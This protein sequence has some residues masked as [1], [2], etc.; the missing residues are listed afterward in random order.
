[1]VCL[2]YLEFG[3]ATT[4]FGGGDGLASAM[5][6]GV[7]L[8][9][10]TGPILASSDGELSNKITAVSLNSYGRDFLC[11]TLGAAPERLPQA[12]LEPCNPRDMWSALIGTR[13]FWRLHRQST[14][15]LKTCNLSMEMQQL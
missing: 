2:L 5:V 7:C 13:H 1:M 14:R 10:H 4:E 11:L 6:E 12:L 9:S 15:R 3:F 8:L